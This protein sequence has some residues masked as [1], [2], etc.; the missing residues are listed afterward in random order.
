MS[1]TGVYTIIHHRPLQ[2]GQWFDVAWWYRSERRWL[3]GRRLMHAQRI[4][5]VDA[6]LGAVVELRFV[7]G[8]EQHEV[9]DVLRLREACL[10]LVRIFLADECGRRTLVLVQVAHNRRGA[11]VRMNRIAPDLVKLCDRKS[12]V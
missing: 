5:I 3:I 10:Q 11:A 4:A 8:E 1:T 12:G 2:G 6:H 7:A 9:G